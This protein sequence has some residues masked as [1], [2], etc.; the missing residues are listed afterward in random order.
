MQCHIKIFQNKYKCVMSICR[1]VPSFLEFSLVFFVV[2]SGIVPTAPFLWLHFFYGAGEAGSSSHT[3][4]E[5]FKKNEA[6]G[7][8]WDQ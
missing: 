6:R 3:T 1:S 8:S 7:S 2:L 4:F 5:D